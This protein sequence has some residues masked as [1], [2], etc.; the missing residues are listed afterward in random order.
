MSQTVTYEVRSWE[1]GRFAHVVTA[2]GEL[3]LHSAPALRETLVRLT[4]LGRMDLVV[5]MAEATFVDSTVIGVLAGR[6]KVLREAG[7]S[8]SLVCHNENVLRT[9]EIAGIERGES[10]RFALPA[11]QV[12][13]GDAIAVLADQRRGIA[14]ADLTTIFSAFQQAGDVSTREHEGLGVGLAIARAVVER[15]GG[16][17][18]AESPGPGKGSTL[19]I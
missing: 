1:A 5:D 12:D 19:L 15:H 4:E 14:A 3:D 17:I 2:S 16:R 7:G 8:L 6:L 13:I 18:W 10:K 11:L 9:F